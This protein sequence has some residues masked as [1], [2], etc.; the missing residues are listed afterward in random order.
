MVN[1]YTK[2]K[3]VETINPEKGTSHVFDVPFR[4]LIVG[5]SGSGKTNTILEMIHRMKNTFINI[6]V[7][8]KNREE[9]LYDLLKEKMKDR[10]QIYDGDIMVGKKTTPNVPPLD[11][12]NVKDD[13]GYEPTLVIF[14]DLV[15]DKEQSIIGQYFIRGRKRNVSCV[16]LTQ[17]YYRSPKII[18]MQC[19]YTILKRNINRRDLASIIR[20][21]SIMTNLEELIKC[22]KIS[23]QSMEDFLLI[24]SSNSTLYRGFSTT[25]LISLGE[26]EEI[27]I[28]REPLKEIVKTP[29]NDIRYDLREL[30]RKSTQAFIEALKSDGIK[31]IFP[32]VDIYN[33]YEIFCED[34]ALDRASKRLFGSEMKKIYMTMS[35]GKIVRYRIE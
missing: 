34:M 5:P 2:T 20:E 31:G 19:N 6:V 16:Y 1:F 18:R 26:G 27:V 12:V 23:T 7:C 29:V 32:F 10:V 28:H 17:S 30:H 33:S 3:K 13:K 15:C 24:D 14:D 8:V 21:T 4:C 11:E 25:P 35:D 22:Y 9:P